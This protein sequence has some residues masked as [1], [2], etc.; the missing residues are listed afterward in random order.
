[1]W[2][3]CDAAFAYSRH[4]ACRRGRFYRL[5]AGANDQHDDDA[6]GNGAEHAGNRAERYG[7]DHDDRDNPE[8]R[9]G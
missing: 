2:R 9:A 1:M 3:N 8:R 6:F 7:S 4:R 5:G